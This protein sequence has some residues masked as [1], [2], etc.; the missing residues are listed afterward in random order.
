MKRGFLNVIR[1]RLINY[2][3]GLTDSVGGLSEYGIVGIADRQMDNT[4]IINN[5]LFEIFFMM[6]H[7]RYVWNITIIPVFLP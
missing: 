1:M 7:L 6:V 2:F 5:T 3:F 4:E